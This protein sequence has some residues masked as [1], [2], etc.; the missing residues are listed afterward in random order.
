[1][2]VSDELKSRSEFSD[3]RF[4]ACI[5]FTQSC[6]VLYMTF[7]CLGTVHMYVHLSISCL[8]LHV[9]R[10]TY[11]RTYVYISCNQSTCLNMYSRTNTHFTHHL[12]LLPCFSPRTIL[13]LI[14]ILS[15]LPFQTFTLTI[16][17]HSSFPFSNLLCC[18]SPS[19]HSPFSILPTLP[20]TGGDSEAAHG[21]P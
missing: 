4:C 5:R 20:P 14:S 21:E 16:P 12:S 15:S 13:P 18:P 7:T 10:Q 1:M 11:V 3:C 17:L 2:P 8:C 9:Y 6:Y 19:S